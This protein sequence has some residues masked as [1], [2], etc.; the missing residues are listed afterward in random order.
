V[1]D[2][3]II[4]AGP[5]GATLA[6]MA[7]GRFRILLVDRR[8]LDD[9]AAQAPFTKCCGGLL[10][11]DAQAM[12]STMGLGLPREALAGPQLFVV[13]TIDLPRGLERYYQRHYINIDREKFDRWIVS[14][15]PPS[16][17][18]R[19]GCL[20]K[21]YEEDGGSFRIHLA[22]RGGG[23][24]VERARVLVGAD[25][26]SS[27]VRRQAAPGSDFPRTY[28]AIQ[29]WVE[30]DSP[31]PY[32]SVFFD[33]D[34]T[35]FYCWTIPKGDLLVIGG[36]FFPR[37]GAAEKFGML[38]EELARRGCRFGRSL[39][40][41]GA[42][43]FR[44]VSLSQICHGRGNIALVG[45][46]AGWIS[47]SSAEGLSYAMKSAM[48][49]ASALEGGLD[50]FLRRY[51]KNSAGLAGSIFLK[52]LKSLFYFGSGLRMAVMRSGI[53]SLDI[54]GEESR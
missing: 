42:L 37:R 16:V 18:R 53:Q 8:M 29:E 34:L 39:K 22:R 15:V 14:L 52:N 36:A 17:E 21:S 47:P 25:G 12:L 6:R 9:E 7:G 46:T 50:D 24:V 32:F 40:R 5:A 44:P 4:G 54:K 38:K 41:E 28:L 20:F 26:A 11:P 45:E 31:P 33:G 3:A 49:L 43:L 23:T 19:F 10:A 2:I 51:R 35:D 48:E 13:R 1:Y 27:R 30:V